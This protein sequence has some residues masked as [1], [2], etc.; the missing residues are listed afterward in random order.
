MVQAQ[1][2]NCSTKRLG[3]H[4]ARIIKNLTQH[5]KTTGYEVIPHAQLNI[6]WGSILSDVDIL[7]LKDDILTYI[8]VKS[9]RD[10][11]SKAFQQ[12]ERVK[13]YVDYAY[14]ATNKLVKEWN[15]PE[16]GLI[17]VND[18]VVTLVKKPTRFRGRPSFTS[19]VSLK[20]KCLARFL[21][22]GYACRTYVTKYDLARYVYLVRKDECTRECLKEIVTCGNNCNNICPI[23]KFVNGN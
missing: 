19:I 17:S 21:G 1:N 14:V 23:T 4:E 9:R 11:L 6:A 3:R 7:L 18:D 13:C 15:I 12:I 2:I 16:I 22:N 5:F 10:K 20:K 8:E